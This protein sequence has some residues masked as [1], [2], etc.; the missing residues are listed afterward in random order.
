MFIQGSDIT[1]THQEVTD[2]LYKK[3]PSNKFTLEELLP[4][5]QEI[6]D[7]KAAEIRSYLSNDDI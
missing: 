3:F 2:S 5:L 4:A 1:M 7:E 6:F